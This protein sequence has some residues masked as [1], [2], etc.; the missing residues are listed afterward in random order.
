MPLESSSR[1]IGSGKPPSPKLVLWIIWAALLGGV[2]IFRFVLVSNSGATR[3][4][5]LDSEA[6][7]TVML[8]GP[9]LLSL[10]I[11]LLW[12]PRAPDRGKVFVA[13]I[14]GMALAESLTLY[15]VLLFRDQVDLFFAVS[16]GLIASYC[17][18]FVPERPS[19]AARPG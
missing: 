5:H 2:F 18:L 16:V 14:V 7:R 17:P 15:G 4:A 13:C 10:A 9:A 11:R 12:V 3:P 6:V 8:F 19:V 1:A